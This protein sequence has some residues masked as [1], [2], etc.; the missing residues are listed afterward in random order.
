MTPRHPP[1]W[2]GRYGVHGFSVSLRAREGKLIAKWRD[3]SRERKQKSWPDTPAH[4]R[5]AEAWAE[6][7]ARARQERKQPVGL[8]TVAELWQRFTAAEFPHLRPRT[9]VFYT[10]S[11]R[12]W[13]VYVGQERIAE[14]LGMQTVTAFRAF[15]EHQRPRRTFAINTARR[16]I[17]TVKTVYAWGLQQRVLTR[18]DLRAFVF[19]VA[20]EKRPV[21]PA[22]YR[23]EEFEAIL[24]QL[25]LGKATSWRAGGV[26]ALCGYQGSRVNSVLHLRWEDVDWTTATL[27]WRSQWDKLGREE[28]QPIRP[29]ALAVLR[30]IEVWTQGRGWLFP[31]VPRTSTQVTYSGQ[32]VWKALQGAEQRAGVPHRSYRAMHGL[33]RLL[34]NEVLQATGNL[35]LAMAAIRDTDLKVASGYHKP[36]Q[37]L[38]REAFV[39]MDRKGNAKGN[40]YI[41]EIAQVVAPQHWGGRN[42]TC[43]LGNQQN[44]EEGL[45]SGDAAPSHAPQPL[46][47]PPPYPVS[48]P[49]K[50]TDKA[51]GEE[52]QP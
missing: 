23:R 35:A 17:Q 1:V 51:T 47:T 48:E 14:D 29:A 8:L 30:T 19:K 34:F 38:L 24:A 18:N 13:A 50:A 26:L 31:P 25:P 4:R 27:T 41:G 39:A 15:L 9:A 32:A 43:N 28:E 42:R 45:T 22:E 37:D 11:W 49:E 6:R 40:A 33:R 44:E 36:R 5:E 52:P 10:E 3:E 12:E 2:G 16:V 21:S 46:N 20:K 7:F